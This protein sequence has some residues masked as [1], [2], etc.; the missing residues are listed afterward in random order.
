MYRS[1]I[2]N[3]AKKDAQELCNR[4]KKENKSCIVVKANKLSQ[5]T[6][7]EK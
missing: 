7:A 4:L 5:L 2:V 1:R 3:F 6:M